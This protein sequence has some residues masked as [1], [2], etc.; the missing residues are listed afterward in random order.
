[1]IAYHPDPTINAEVASEVLR[2][3][4]VDLRAGLPPRRWTCP[5]CGQSHSRG[6][7]FALGVHRCLACGYLGPG[8]VM[9]DPQAETEPKL[10]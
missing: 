10:V 7:V 3:E 6:H 2:A 5:D 8:G 1:V 9:W 4:V